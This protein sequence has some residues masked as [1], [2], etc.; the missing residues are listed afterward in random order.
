MAECIVDD[1]KRKPIKK[2]LCE[3]HY[4]RVLKRGE[5]GPANSRYGFIKP[6]I[7]HLLSQN[8]NECLEWPY[9]HD[10]RTKRPIV[11]IDRRTRT[12]ARHLLIKKTGR[13]P[14]DLQAAHTCGNEWCVNHNHIQRKSSKQNELDKITHGT[15]LK[16]GKKMSVDAVREI[17]VSA[18][19]SANLGRKHGLTR[20]AIWRIRTGKEWGWATVGLEQP[21]NIPKSKPCRAKS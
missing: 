4:Q 9:K 3:M 16:R 2:Q 7:N 6:Y 11:C 1:C 17:Y 14:T 13:D 5:T 18:D 12:A 8:S 21:K 20:G 15:Y 10:S 19:S